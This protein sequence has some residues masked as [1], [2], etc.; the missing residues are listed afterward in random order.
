M[1]LALLATGAN[2]SAPGARLSASRIRHTST[3]PRMVLDEVPG[4]V[5]DDTA[6]SKR[7]RPTKDPFNPEFYEPFSFEEA[8][9]SSTSALN[10]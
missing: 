7:S 10:L 1:A 5:A 8:F 2:A 3:A 6:G 4:E 9:P